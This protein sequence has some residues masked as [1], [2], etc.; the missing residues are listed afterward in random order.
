MTIINWTCINGV[1]ACS[2]V[3]NTQ[4]RQEKNLGLVWELDSRVKPNYYCM[5][6]GFGKLSW[7]G[8]TWVYCSPT[9]N[10][11]TRESNISIPHNL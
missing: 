4:P 3:I 1:R 5:L 11:S 7:A 2:Y 10:S 9:F 8:I 6:V